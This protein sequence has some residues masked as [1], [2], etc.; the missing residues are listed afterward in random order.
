VHYSNRNSRSGQGV[1]LTGISSNKPVSYESESESES[2]VTTVDQSASLSGNKAY[3]QIHITVRQLRVCWCGVL[4]LTRGRGLSFTMAAEPRQRSHSRVRV[5]WDSWPYFTASDS[6]LPFSSPPTTRRATVDVFDPTTT[7]DFVVWRYEFV[8][9]S[10]PYGV[11]SE[12]VIENTELRSVQIMKKLPV[13]VSLAWLI[14][15]INISIIPTHSPCFN[16]QNLS[17]Y[18]SAVFLNLFKPKDQ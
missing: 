2:H 13:L 10:H 11:C 17:S 1:L 9:S 18:P 6:R 4:S 14:T 8:F 12:S 5:P 15:T 16:P 7:W 3:D